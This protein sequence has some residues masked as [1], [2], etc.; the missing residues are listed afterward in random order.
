MAVRSAVVFEVAPDADLTAATIVMTTHG[1]RQE[2]AIRVA[3]ESGG[4]LTIPDPEL[5]EVP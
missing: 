4:V 1:Y 2:T 3:I 5:E